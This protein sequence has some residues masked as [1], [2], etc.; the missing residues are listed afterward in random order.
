MALLGAFLLFLVQP[1]L[2]KAILPWFGG[3]PAVWVTAMLFFQ[4]FLLLG[5]VGAVVLAGLPGHGQRWLYLGLAVAALLSLPILPGAHWRP[6]S[7]GIA[8]VMWLLTCAVGLPYLW[9][10]MTAPLVQVWYARVCPGQS[11]YRLYAFSNLGSLAALLGYPG[12]FEPVFPLR[13]QAWCWTAI[14]GVVV[15][16]GVALAW[17]ANR[18]GEQYDSARGAATVEKVEENNW[19]EVACWLG[20]PALATGALLTITVRLTLD[21]AAVPLLWVLPLAVY[22]LT[23]VIAF[24]GERYY[25]RGLVTAV[26]LGVAIG[27]GILSGMASR[28]GF[29]PP[30]MAASV[31]GEM[32]AY[33]WLICPWVGWL[34]HPWAVG[35]L[36]LIWLLLAGLICHGELYRLRPAAPERLTRF[37][38]CVAGGGILGS[39]GVVILAPAVFSSYREWHLVAVAL[40][41]LA[42]VLLARGRSADGAR[43]CWRSRPA[44]VVIGVLTVLACLVQRRAEPDLV[45]PGCRVLN[46]SRNFHGVL[47]VVEYQSDPAERKVNILYHGRIVHGFQLTDAEQH[48]EPTAYFTRGSGLGIV[49]EELRRR[50]G[51]LRIGVIGLGVGTIAAYGQAGDR[52]V[53]YELDPA[54]IALHPKYFS[55]LSDCP[56]EIEVLA[57]DGRVLLESQPPQGYDLLVL[58][59]FTGDA[60]PVHLLT[61]EALMGYRRHL[62]PGGVVAYN[63]SNRYVNLLPV[64]AAL[65]RDAGLPLVYFPPKGQGGEP[66]AYPSAWVM[67]GGEPGLFATPAIAENGRPPP[68]GLSPVLWTDQ[69]SNLLA[70]L[71]R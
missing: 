47:T 38:L 29:L 66:L 24:A 8:Q 13:Q 55:F 53:F 51:S 1:L 50:R 46:Q 57:G 31:R 14:F 23:Y 34:C 43:S 21:V 62:R 67:L 26:F 33:L 20:L 4:V 65:A 40:A 52:L 54:V 37:Y 9:L 16:L 61:R 2:A 64:A 17:T 69:F 32:M 41:I 35:G 25:W 39:C 56:A 71:K 28:A 7:V 42:G 10:A 70:V 3:G 48:R 63:I 58:D 5:Y 27:L 45:R 60:I 11:P 6:E 36:H 68:D 12:W 44:L 22:L 15:L 49:I 30:A 59:A 18:P 19:R